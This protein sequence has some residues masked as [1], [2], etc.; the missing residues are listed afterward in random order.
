M[1]Y[2]ADGVKVYVV[3]TKDESFHRYVSHVCIM[4][5]FLTQ[6]NLTSSDDVVLWCAIRSAPFYSLPLLPRG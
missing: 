3:Y 1:I 5:L 4:L 6:I 2:R